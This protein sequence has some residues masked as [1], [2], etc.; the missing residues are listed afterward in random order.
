MLQPVRS[1]NENTKLA[2]PAG[3]RRFPIRADAGLG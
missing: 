2:V 1:A 3:V